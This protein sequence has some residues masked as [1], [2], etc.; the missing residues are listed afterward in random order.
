MH[1][2]IDAFYVFWDEQIPK[3]AQIIK[4]SPMF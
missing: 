1:L 3:N 2:S 4:Y